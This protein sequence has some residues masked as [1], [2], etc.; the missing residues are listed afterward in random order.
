MA[1]RLTRN[2][3]AQFLPNH[4]LIKAFESMDTLVSTD[5]PL[6]VA[7]AQ[8]TANAALEL[9]TADVLGVFDKRPQ[10]ISVRAGDG[11]QVTPDIAGF[12]VTVDLHFLINAVRAFLPRQ[13][14]PAPG[15]DDTQV[16]LASKIFGR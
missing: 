4:E 14:P 9:S 8:A 15:P 6:Q 2:Q 7:Q 5:L 3:L 13:L 12:V 16:I 1:T 11:I 10:V